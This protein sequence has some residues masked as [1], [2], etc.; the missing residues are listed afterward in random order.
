MLDLSFIE[1]QQ[2]KNGDL[3]VG[4]LEKLGWAMYRSRYVE[5]HLETEIRNIC[6]KGTWHAIGDSDNTRMMKYQTSS[7]VPKSWKSKTL[8]TMFENIKLNIF[9]NVLPNKKYKWGGKYAQE[10]GY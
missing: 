4:D 10:S 8:A 3:V 9:D 7:T 6:G 5:S 1:R 2:Y